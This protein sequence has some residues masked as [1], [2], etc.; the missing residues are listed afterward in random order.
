[1]KTKEF[2]AGIAIGLIVG[3]LLGFFPHPYSI[4]TSGDKSFKINRLTG[5]T[6]IFHWELGQWVEVPNR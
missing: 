6:W 2:F 1:M 3:S 4:T 5:T